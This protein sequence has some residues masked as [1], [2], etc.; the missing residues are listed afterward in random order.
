MCDTLRVRWTVTP[1]AAP[2]PWISCSGCGGMRAFQSSDKIRLN[3]NGRKLD[4]WLIYKCLTCDKTWNRPLFE[5]KNVRDIDPAIL[6]ALQSN[7][8]EWIRAESFNLDALRRKSQRIDEFPEFD[9]LREVLRETAGWTRLEIELVAPLPARIRLDR[10]LASELKLSRTRL[11]TLRENGLLRTNPD[12]ADILRRGISTGIDVMIDLAAIADRELSW[13]PL[14][15]GS[16][17]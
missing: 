6:E 16:P 5:R 7:D 12:R 4:A 1:K 9:I 14:A 3:A 8:P 15:T 10:L 2:Q 17:R 13:G 11:R